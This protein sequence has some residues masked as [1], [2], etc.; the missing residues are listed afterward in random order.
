MFLTLA[1]PR[2][3]LSQGRAKVWDATL[4]FCASIG[5]LSPVLADLFKM[6][7]RKKTISGLWA[8]IPA[9]KE[10]WALFRCTEKERTDQSR[11]L[12]WVKVR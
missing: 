11:E 9:E 2:D 6:G 10:P 8:W 12:C 5:Y 1:I 7:F 4:Q 3:Q